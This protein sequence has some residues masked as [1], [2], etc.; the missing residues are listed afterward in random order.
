MFVFPASFTK[1]DEP[2]PSYAFPFYIIGTVFLFVGMLYCAIIIEHSSKEYYFKPNTPSKIYWLQ[3][4]NQHVGDQVFNAYMAVEEGPNSNM[5]TDLQ[6]IKSTRIPKYDGR[7]VEIYSTLFFTI[8]G[9]IVQFVGLRGLHASVILAQLGATLL[10]SILRTC[11]RTQRMTPEENKLREERSLTSWKQ[12]ELD[13]FA[14]RLEN[15]EYFNLTTVPLCADSLSETSS[16]SSTTL[17]QSSKCQV[18]QLIRTRAL[19]AEL[20]SQSG[21]GANSPWDEIPI[22]RAAQSLARAIEATMNQ[23][24]SRGIELEPWFYLNLTFEYESA[25]P[26]TRSKNRG[27]YLKP[28]RRGGNA[29]RWEVPVNDLEAILGLWVWSLHKSDEEQRNWQKPLS[30]LVGPSHTAADKMETYLSF[31]KW[32]FRQ[33]EARMVPSKTI[34]TRQRLFGFQSERDTGDQ[35]V[36]VMETQN[37]LETMAAQDIYVHFLRGA[38]GQLKQLEGQSDVAPGIQSQFLAQN[39][40]IDDLVHCFEASELGS[41]ED[42]LVCIVPVLKQQGLLPKLSADSPRIRKRVEGLVQNGNWTEAFSLLWWICQR[43]E[44]TEFEHS[45]Y[46]LCFL[47]RRALMSNDVEGREEGMKATRELLKGDIR[48]TLC[49]QAR[50]SLPS[51][52]FQESEWWRNLFGQLAWLLWKIE[53]RLPGQKG[54]QAYLVPFF[55]PDSL[56]EIGEDRARAEKSAAT[57]QEWLTRGNLAFDRDD[58]ENDDELCFEWVL[59]H[60]QYAF[61]Y[62]LIMRWLEVGEQCPGLVKH[63]WNLAAKYQSSW[64]V[65]ILQQ[66][67]VD[68]ETLDPMMRSALMERVG[69][70]DV[71]GTRLLLQNGANPNGN[72]QVRGMRPLIMAAYEGN[73]DIVKL[74]LQY[75]ANIEIM[76]HAAITPVQWASK[77]NQFEMVQL[78]LS[79]GADVNTAEGSDVTMVHAAIMNQRVEML[80]LL[81][82]NGANVNAQDD[83]GQTPL[84]FTVLWP[85][86]PMLQIILNRNPDLTLRDERGRTALEIANEMNYVEGI[87]LLAA[88]YRC[89]SQ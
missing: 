76:D 36:M 63:A 16:F 79:S 68:I 14:F 18:K 73:V 49:S 77:N 71:A 30:R 45:I 10:M 12:Q 21:L 41:R 85:S 50:T 42:A 37:N 6:Y 59:L 52:W 17:V 23:L 48:R 60:K 13:S 43:S 56:F 67:G 69:H 83:S 7:Y 25:V 46:E 61:L 31:H 20:T 75:G 55:T 29:F 35:D 19:L 2:V 64:V 34:D 40:H 74:L 15:V 87:R 26:N 28:L 44:S 53:D 72:D 82:K 86:T 66:R 70:G 9:F 39:S 89:D 5:T 62:W 3:P 80:D 22:R 8:L 58:E 32:I 33:T 84:M 4:G 51:N 47:C 1:D 57:L 38:L 78:L 24:S 54:L 27:E 11:L 81:L 88:A 65:R